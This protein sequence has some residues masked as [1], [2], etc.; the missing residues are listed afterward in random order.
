[1]PLRWI[2]EDKQLLYELDADPRRP[3]YLGP[4]HKLIS[5]VFDDKYWYRT[6]CYDDCDDDTDLG[7]Y[8]AIE[9]VDRLTGES[10]RLSSGARG[11]HELLVFGDFVYWG[12]YGH[13]VDGGVFRVPKAGGEEERIRIAPDRRYED[14]VEKLTADPEG[15]LVQ[16]TGT[17]GWIPMNGERARLILRVAEDTGPAVHDGDSFYVAE[18][19][20]PR[21]GTSD[22]GSIHRIAVADNNDTKLAGPVRSPSA[23]TTF[24]P[25]VYFMLSES[26][27]I[28]S[29]PKL[30]GPLKQV[31]ANGPRIDPCDE[32]LR[33]WADDRGLFWQRGKRFLSEGDRIYFLPWSAIERAK[34]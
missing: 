25:N 7:P 32:S 4:A 13:Q 3:K 12:V 14:K 24:G 30:G 10:K 16:G 27:D 11:L 26:G 28:W 8:Y 29:V 1:M 18:R 6:K 34:H 23:I 22:S 33:L 20:A 19:G 15:I 9:R 21:W 31:L 2:T 5:S 17:I